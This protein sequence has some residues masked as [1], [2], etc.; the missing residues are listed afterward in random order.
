MR[1]G[2]TDAPVPHP[3]V[4]LLPSVYV[5][6]DL[7]RRL[8]AAIDQVLAPVGLTLDSLPAYLDPDTAPEDLLDWL[9]SWVA[10]PPRGSLDP[11]EQRRLVRS[12]HALHAARGTPAGLHAAL[13]VALGHPVDVEVE[14]GGGVAWSTTPGA[15]PPGTGVPLL[16]VR[17]TVPAPDET[18][19]RRAD[20]VVAVVKPAHLPHRTE[21]VG[22]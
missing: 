11:A 9:S 21:L 2:L 8:G 4:A 7:T 3:L 18:A 14:E 22:R 1:A 6:D 12:A 17:V 15:A 10:L 5:E 16:V 20:D 13:V 19:L